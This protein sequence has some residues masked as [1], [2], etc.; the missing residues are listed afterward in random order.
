MSCFKQA[1]LAL[2]HPRKNETYQQVG[3]GFGGSEAAAWRYVDE[4]LEVL[5]SWA[6]GLHEALAGLGEGDFVTIE[7]LRCGHRSS[8][9]L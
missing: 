4:T 2:A 1:L 7:L 6:P 8:D 9:G 5:A 3:A